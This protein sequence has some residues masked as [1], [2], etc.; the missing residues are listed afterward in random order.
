MTMPYRLTTLGV[1][2]YDSVRGGVVH[3]PVIFKYPDSDLIENSLLPVRTIAT[4]V[5]ETCKFCGWVFG[6]DS[7]PHFRPLQITLE[8]CN[9]ALRAAE[10]YCKETTVSWARWP[11]VPL[12]CLYELLTHYSPWLI[13]WYVWI[14]SVQIQPYSLALHSETTVSR[15]RTI[16]AGYCARASRQ[17]VFVTSLPVPIFGDRFLVLLKRK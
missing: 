7:N 16:A 3:F 5:K 11:Y 8:Y 12:R 13:S 9:F 14:H 2:P 17:A 1:V 4:A 10:Q 6:C 15:R